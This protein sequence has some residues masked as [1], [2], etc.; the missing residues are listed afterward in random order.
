MSFQLYNFE[1]GLQPSY[2]FQQFCIASSISTPLLPQPLALNSI[3]LHFTGTPKGLLCNVLIPIGAGSNEKT[4]LLGHETLHNPASKINQDGP[5]SM[6][7]ELTTLA[8]K[9]KLHDGYLREESHENPF[10]GHATVNKLK[11]SST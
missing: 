8:C 4:P 7:I 10:F 1:S 6:E 3:S 11:W 9:M 2:L 5:L